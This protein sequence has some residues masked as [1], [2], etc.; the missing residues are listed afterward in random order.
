MCTEYF[1]PVGIR[2]GSPYL[3]YVLYSRDEDYV[4]MW[5]YPNLWIHPTNKL[6]TTTE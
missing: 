5:P 4:E 3:L 1:S 6:T 2:P